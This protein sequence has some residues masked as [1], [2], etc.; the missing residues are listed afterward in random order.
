MGPTMWKYY[1][2]LH[3]GIGSRLTTIWNLE[4]EITKEN[5]KSRE[6]IDQTKTQNFKE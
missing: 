1:K 2:Y 4:L 6:M 5:M 3:K